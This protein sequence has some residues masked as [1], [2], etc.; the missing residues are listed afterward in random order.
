MSKIKFIFTI[1]S[2]FFLTFSFAQTWQEMI[3]DPNANFNEIKQKFDAEWEGKEYQKGYGWKQFKRWEH[4][5]QNRVKKDGSFPT[6]LE[7]EIAYNQHQAALKKNNNSKRFDEP[8][9]PIG[10]FDLSNGLGRINVIQI[11]PNNSDVIY[12]GASSGGLWKSVDNGQNWR[13]LTDYLPTVSVS[14][15]AINP[16]NSNT[17]YISTGDFNHWAAYGTGVWKSHDGGES[18]VPTGLQVSA[19]SQNFRGGKIAF[20]PQDTSMLFCATTNS[21]YRTENNGEQWDK[22]LFTG[23]EDFEFDPSQP[24]VMYAVSD[25][26]YYRSEDF[27][28]SFEDLS[29]M[30]SGITDAR[31]LK[32]GVTPSNPQVVYILGG[33]DATL[34]WKSDDGGLSFEAKHDTSTGNPLSNQYWYDMAF[35]INPNN[36][37]E[38]FIGGVNLF[39]SNDSGRSFSGIGFSVHADVHWLEFFDGILYC[40]N[41]GGI[42][43]SYDN[44]TTWEYI[45]Q[46]LQITQY[47]DFSNSPIDVN[48]ISAGAQ[49]NGTHLLKDGNWRRYS[50]GDGL[51]TEIDHSNPDIIYHSYQRGTILK[52]TDAGASHF[53]IFTDA[54]KTDRWETPIK[55]DPNNSNIVYVGYGELWKSFD[56]GITST[57]ISNF[58]SGLL[59]VIQ[60]SESDSDVIAVAVGD[61]LYLTND[62]GLN[63][64]RISDPLPFNNFSSVLFHPTNPN[65]IWITFGLY[66]GEPKVYYTENQGTEWTDISQGLPN[67]PAHKIIYQ[68]DHP[69]DCLYLATEVGVYYRDKTYD[70]W[71]PYMTELPNTFVSDIE[72]VPETNILR[73]CS[74]GRGIWENTVIKPN[75]YPPTT[76]YTASESEVCPGSNILFTNQSFNYSEIIEWYFEGG[77]PET[78]LEENPYI[79]YPSEGIYDVRLIVSNGVENDTLTME[80]FIE[81]SLPPQ[82]TFNNYQGFETS[83]LSSDWRINNPD[84]GETWKHVP[85]VG[86][87]GNSTSSI[88]MDNFSYSSPGER[89][90]LISPTIDLTD[91]NEPY[92]EFDYAYTLYSNGGEDYPD[93]LNIYYSNDCGN[94]L[95]KIWGKGGHEL[96]TVPATTNFFTPDNEDWE[97]ITIQLNDLKSEGML[98]FYFVNI[99]GYGNSLYLDNINLR[100]QPLLVDNDNDGYTNDVD[101]DDE[102]PNI[103]PDAE[104]IVYNGI[105]DDC[106][107]N[108]LDDDLDQDGFLLADDCNDQDSNIN[109]D[110]TEIPYN[111]IDDDC[112]ENTLDD[113]LDQD[114]FLLADDCNDQDSN[115]NPDQTEIPYNGIDEDCNENTLDDDLDQD[116]FLLA[117]DCDDENPNINP[118]AEEIANNGIDED[119]DGMDLTSSTHELANASIN[120]FPNPVSTFIRIEVLGELTYQIRLFNLEG[121]LIKKYNNES[122]IQVN[123]LENG[124]YLLEVL[125]LQ[126]NQKIVEKIIVAH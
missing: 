22:T 3:M 64:S 104:E 80:E 101:C 121:R 90:Y 66:S 19:S 8:W 54:E 57:K 34:T 100:E 67:F 113:D 37:D 28:A 59:S 25:F 84:D 46:G 10:P 68:K 92:L 93:S 109:P 41:D 62:G 70:E 96:A 95:T 88:F 81:V 27:G 97:K 115:I 42:N 79:T 33:G 82:V 117:D 43:R 18:W 35:E 49:D 40:G 52:T 112:N 9:Q 114:G 83:E 26:G 47:Y 77:V 110:Q 126:S 38:L 13:A 116:G 7:M 86:G 50:G 98:Q 15:I 21:F 29:N 61:I 89:D 51:Q 55:V 30:V 17:I 14:G 105:D 39:R 48:R 45:S 58:D 120:I 103:N 20:N 75:A 91:S 107:E 124:I 69:D 71:V 102:N 44:G 108:T 2:L 60:I 85:S 16:L 106:D 65:K 31:R 23:I 87:F 72:I 125:D 53:V 56:G 78:S 99:C 4:F 6:P 122:T 119:C 74:Y 123:N 32:L 94:T 63:W 36:E 24:S 76:R 1:A 73:A 5:W 12:I 11:D 111:G 118:D